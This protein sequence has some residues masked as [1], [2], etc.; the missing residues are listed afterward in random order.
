MSFWDDWRELSNK[1]Q[2]WKD[3]LDEAVRR[4]D[5][6]ADK[7]REKGYRYRY[8]GW[9]TPDGTP[10]FDG[11][12]SHVSIFKHLEDVAKERNID[13]DLEAIGNWLTGR[14]RSDE[15]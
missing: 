15:S 12:G 13:D 5:A 2:A 3:A 1:L 9:Q 14:E 6:E 10:V 7:M 4:D 11:P 8:G